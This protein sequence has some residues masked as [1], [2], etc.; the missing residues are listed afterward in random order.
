MI[1]SAQSLSKSYGGREIL[2]DCS[3]TLNTGQC[4]LIR[5]PSGGGKSTLIRILSL[6]EPADSGCVFHG[7]RRL[8]V[9]RPQKTS[10]YPFLTLVFQQLFLW[11]NLTMRQNL[12]MVLAHRPNHP[13]PRTAMELLERLAI[14][15]LLDRHPHQCSLGERQRLAIARSLLSEARFLLLDE[16]TSALDRA[17]RSVLIQELK[18]TI[19][20]DRGV[21]LITHDDDGYG[22]VVD[23][24]FELENG[25][26]RRL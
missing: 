16:P 21:V 18:T 1:L 8:D 12:S 25:Q 2:L 4:L 26:L 24:S 20:R 19:A 15:K 11:P 23:Q 17:N 6:L 3:F 14:D 9:S 22:E 13:L 10:A 7:D 5:G